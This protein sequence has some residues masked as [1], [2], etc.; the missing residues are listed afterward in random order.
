M[1]W[2]SI[3]DRMPEINTEVL[4]YGQDNADWEMKIKQCKYT[5]DDKNEHFKREEPIWIYDDHCCLLQLENV[6]HWMLLPELPKE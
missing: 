5:G 4:A 3:K 6:T 2:I 1:E